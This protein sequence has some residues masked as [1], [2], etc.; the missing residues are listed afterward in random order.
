MDD[1]LVAWFLL[2]LGHSGRV[3]GKVQWMVGVRARR[4]AEASRAFGSLQLAR[5]VHT[6]NCPPSGDSLTQL[7]WGSARAAPRCE[8]SSSV[9][10]INEPLLRRLQCQQ[11]L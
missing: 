5:K 9:R 4:S 2:R 8:Q 6:I 7:S 11:T 3:R 1:L 10:V